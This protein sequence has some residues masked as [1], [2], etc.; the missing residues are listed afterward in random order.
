MKRIGMGAAAWLAVLGSDGMAQ[1]RPPVDA[2]V[3][4]EIGFPDAAHHEARITAI[5]RGVPAGPLRVQMSRSSPGRYALHEFA[6]NVYDVSATDG[7]GRA[8]PLDRSDPYGWT[9][10]SGH[11][12]IVRVSYTLFGDRGDGTYAQ[13]DATHA[14]LNMPATILWAV[15]YDDAPIELRFTPADAAWKVTTSLPEAGAPF[16]YRACN[17]QALMDSPVELSDHLVRAWPVSDG[18]RRYTIRLAVHHSGDAA[19]VDRLAGQVKALIQQHHA[20]FGEWPRFDDGTY[21]FIADYLPQISGDGMEH[22]NSTIVTGSAPLDGT[23]A[24]QLDTIAHEFIHAWNVERLR[25]AGL[26][27][28]DFI[29]ANTTPS[30]W[31]AEGFTSYLGPL[32]L[33]RAGLTKDDAFLATL[34]PMV[35]LIENA[36]ARAI[37]GPREMSIRAPFA[38]AAT[39]IDPVSPRV[40]VSYYP[41]GAVI[42]LALDLSIRQ[43]FPGKSLDDYM[44]SLWRIYGRTERPYHPDDLRA[45]LAE[46]TG[47]RAFAERFFATAI[48]GHALPDLA[49]LLAQAGFVLAPAAPQAGWLG[50]RRVSVAGRTVTLAEAPSPGSPLYLAGLDR[51]DRIVS[52]DNAT[53]SSAAAWNTRLSRLSPGTTISVRFV[54]RGREGSARLVAIADP[55]L[56]IT[57]IEAHGGTLSPAQEAFRREWLSAK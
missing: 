25:P 12:G 4:Y 22:R 27:P 17:L 21:T 29:R 51:G 42:A 54:Q 9:V 18:E 1:Q 52:I 32:M 33:R 50:A 28:F 20:L 56:R 2:P 49:P 43:R 23:N 46:V 48:A 11:D 45:A 7:A 47:D 41:Y 16:S 55:T 31:L 14:H 34:S 30:L 39:S 13:I 40:Y 38:D 53:V 44:R 57:R 8:L 6:K 5:W 15:G 24:D 35:D 26:E 37:A 36:P 19:A 3:R 10:S